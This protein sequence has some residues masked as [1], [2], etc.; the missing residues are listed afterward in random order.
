MLY[1]CFP[2]TLW[3]RAIN[4][5]AEELRRIE[6]LLSTNKSLLAID[7]DNEYETKL[8]VARLILVVQE[9]HDLMPS[10]PTLERLR[11]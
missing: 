10:I 7:D 2:S 4:N 9:A 11:A 8:A 1:A 6:K 3:V 5:A